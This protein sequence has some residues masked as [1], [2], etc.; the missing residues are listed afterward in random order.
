MRYTAT[1][2]RVDYYNKHTELMELKQRALDDRYTQS[3]TLDVWYDSFIIWVD[4]NADLV[5]VS[6]LINT[7]TCASIHVLLLIADIV[8]PITFM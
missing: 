7:G 1:T 4:D 3:R 6:G 8:T 2:G 5:N